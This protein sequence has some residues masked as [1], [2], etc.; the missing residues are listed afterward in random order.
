MEAASLP[1]LSHFPQELRAAYAAIHAKYLENHAA[2]TAAQN[3][4]YE[5]A[6]EIA[7]CRLEM[8][9]MMTD[10]LTQFNQI[11]QDNLQL[12]QQVALLDSQV[13]WLL[14]F[15]MNPMRLV[16]VQYVEQPLD[17]VF[18]LSD[19]STDRQ[20]FTKDTLLLEILDQ[21]ILKEYPEYANF[22]G[23]ER[24]TEPARV[25]NPPSVGSDHFE[26]FSHASHSD[27][28]EVPFSPLP[29]RLG[30]T[31]VTPIEVHE[32]NTE[33]IKPSRKKPKVS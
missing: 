32:D 16:P 6:L 14:Q 7:Q 25:S 11:T 5:S 19:K 17:K 1:D 23:D 28:P 15:V 30:E 21:Q 20:D 31:P 13:S 24:S 4:Y 29:G 2:L 12:E 3:K 18:W 33:V 9:T 26:S 8:K 27:S 10:V 22:L